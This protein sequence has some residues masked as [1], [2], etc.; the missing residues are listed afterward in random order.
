M[1]ARPTSFL[2]FCQSELDRIARESARLMHMNRKR[3]IDQF[4]AEPSMFWHA[5]RPSLTTQEAIEESTRIIF[6]FRNLATWKQQNP[7]RLKELEMAKLNRIAARYFRRFGRRVWAE[8][9]S[10]A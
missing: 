8:N 4:K 2:D 7:A 5:I 10:A 1:N 9:R 3:R 6:R